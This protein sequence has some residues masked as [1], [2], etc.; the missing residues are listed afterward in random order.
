MVSVN[1]DLLKKYPLKAED[2]IWNV[3][4]KKVCCIEQLVI[5]KTTC[6]VIQFGQIRSLSDYGLKL[7]LVPYIVCAKG[8][9]SGDVHI[10]W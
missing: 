4:G 1:F 9:N 5:F 2:I 6:A 10:I 3:S 8:V 7:P